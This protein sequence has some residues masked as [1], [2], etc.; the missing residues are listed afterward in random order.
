M[1][2]GEILILKERINYLVRKENPMSFSFFLINEN[3]GIGK[4]K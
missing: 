4:T 2:E 3:F 1:G